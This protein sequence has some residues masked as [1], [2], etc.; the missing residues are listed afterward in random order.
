MNIRKSSVDLNVDASDPLKKKT[1]SKEKNNF[2]DID[3][4]N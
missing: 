1:I 4:L 2:D 3:F